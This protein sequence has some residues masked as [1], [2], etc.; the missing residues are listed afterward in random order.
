M[1]KTN[2]K[3]CVSTKSW[4]FATKVVRNMQICI[5]SENRSEKYPIFIHTR[6][7]IHIDSRSEIS[8]FDI[9]KRTINYLNLNIW[10]EIHIFLPSSSSSRSKKWEKYDKNCNFELYKM[11]NKSWEICNQS[12]EKYANCLVLF[13]PLWYLRIA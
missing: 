3:S 13:S 7:T 2:N 9:Q 4:E 10:W 8:Y 6:A 1:H 11:N 5:P 12:C